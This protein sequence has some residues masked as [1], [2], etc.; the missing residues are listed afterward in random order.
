MGLRQTISEWVRILKDA[1]DFG[2]E[3]PAAMEARHAM[4][5]QESARL[6]HLLEQ[7]RKASQE[8]DDLI[9]K[10]RAAGAVTGN[11]VVDGPASYIRRA[12]ALDGPF[13]TSCFQRHHEITRITAAPEPKDSDGTPANWVQCAKCKT[14]FRSDRISQ[15]L[16]PGQATRSDDKRQK[17]EDTRQKAQPHSHPSS[18]LLHPSP[19]QEAEPNPPRPQNPVPGSPTPDPTPRVEAP[20]PG[21]AQTEPSSKESDAPKPG[22]PARKPR[23]NPKRDASLLAETP[24]GETEPVEKGP[25]SPQVAIGGP[26][27]AQPRTRKPKNQRPE[28]TKTAGRLKAAS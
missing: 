8:K 15:Y 4:F 12:T 13:C 26:S 22:K 27:R 17:A 9:A 18:V 6:Q 19:D 24:T 28:R 5:A 3:F 2:P 14:P 23:R 21:P 7:T 20:K 25:E 11:M 10:L 1:L 16:N